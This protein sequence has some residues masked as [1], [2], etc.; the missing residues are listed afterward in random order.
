MKLVKQ[1]QKSARGDGEDNGKKDN[2]GKNG[3]NKDD[4]RRKQVARQQPQQEHQLS[5]VD[6][7]PET[8]FPLQL[9]HVDKNI[10]RLTRWG[11]EWEFVI[12][13]N[14]A[15]FA[16]LIWAFWLPFP[17]NKSIFSRISIVS[18]ALGFTM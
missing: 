5:D 17:D 13:I 1:Q 14:L 15:A 18:L 7:D 3:N 4:D 8:T 12:I 6:M 11:Y 9:I 2:E 10:L 16:G